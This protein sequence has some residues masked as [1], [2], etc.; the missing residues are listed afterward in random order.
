VDLDP[1]EIETL[2]AVVLLTPHTSIDYDSVIRAAPLVVDTHSGLQP[3]E[4]PNV[5]NIWVPEVPSATP[6][7]S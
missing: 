7:L 1:A 5:V 4:A 3:R 6:V 2:D